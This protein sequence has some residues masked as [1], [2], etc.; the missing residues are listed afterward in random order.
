MFITLT[1][2]RLR[3]LWGFFR[4]SWHGLR[5]TLQMRR[6]PGFVSMRN[7]GWGYLHYTAS[8]WRSEEELKQFARSGAHLEAMKQTRQLA[9]ELRTYTYEGESLPVW[10]EVRR[11]LL[12]KGK[13]LNLD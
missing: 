10:S 6:L 3:S 1:S 11:L 5:I 12:E 8:A 13:V 2:I 9:F 7:T 4:L